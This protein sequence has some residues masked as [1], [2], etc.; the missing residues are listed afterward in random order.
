MTSE[1]ALPAPTI[2]N[3]KQQIELDLEAKIYVRTQ[4]GAVLGLDVSIYY[5]TNLPD[6]PGNIQKRLVEAV[7]EV[8]SKHFVDRRLDTIRGWYAGDLFRIENMDWLK[9]GIRQ[10]FGNHVTVNS[11]NAKVS[12][13]IKEFTIENSVVDKESGCTIPYS[14][15]IEVYYQD[16]VVKNPDID[17][18]LFQDA[19][20]FMTGASTP[21][22]LWSRYCDG[23]TSRANIDSGTVC[24]HTRLGAETIDGA[25]IISRSVV[26]KN[27]DDL[28]KRLLISRM[29][30]HAKTETIFAFVQILLFGLISPAIW[31]AAV[32]SRRSDAVKDLNG[33]SDRYGSVYHYL[34][35]R[36][37]GLILMPIVIF[38]ATLIV[39]G[40][41][42][43]VL[44]GLL[45]VC[46]FSITI[47]PMIPVASILV[48]PVVG[49]LLCLA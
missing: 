33:S 19:K 24:G 17:A 42:A 20:Q 3:K 7:Q 36:L 39:T 35:T 47:T 41:V 12:Y 48:G 32:N 29:E 22:E 45:A 30:K 28:F 34:S 6:Q 18:V 43:A 44:G 16:A 13:N 21:M 9:S 37:T 27:P 40:C 10:I 5:A 31:L 14:A 38:S 23:N 2:V 46:G 49:L 1:T 25:V 15:S 11:A 4:T 26:F 8:A